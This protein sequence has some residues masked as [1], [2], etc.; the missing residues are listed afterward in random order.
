MNRRGCTHST[1]T[2]NLLPILPLTPDDTLLTITFTGD[3]RVSTQCRE[4]I[5]GQSNGAETVTLNFADVYTECGYDHLYL[6]D[7][8]SVHAPLV[9]SFNGYPPDRRVTLTNG[10]ALLRFTSDVAQVKDG[11]NV[12]FSFSACPNDC[13]GNGAC[14]GTTCECTNNMT[15]ADCSIELCP[16]KCSGYGECGESGCVCDATRTGLDCT[17]VATQS[18]WS[19]VSSPD[20]PRNAVF[21]S[22]Q[23]ALRTAHASAV[24]DLPAT[25]SMWTF[26]GLAAGFLNSNALAYFDPDLEEWIEVISNKY[27]NVLVI[28][29][30]S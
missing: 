2:S 19:F 23:L 27:V 14:T 16:G 11:Y 24:I 15:G 20:G 8:D 25:S 10:V 4:R 5:V 22:S 7:G 28:R 21:N 30:L 17:Q 13:S 6:Y 29:S 3:Y 26:G 9:A 18:R 12:T 1:G